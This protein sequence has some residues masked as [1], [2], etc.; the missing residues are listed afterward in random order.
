[1][2]RIVAALA[3]LAVLAVAGPAAAQGPI[4]ECGSFVP[5][6]QSGPP[7]HIAYRGYWTFGLVGPVGHGFTPVANLTTRNV[8]CRDARSASLTIVQINRIYPWHGFVLRFRMTGSERGTEDYDI[9]CTRG[10]EV[11]HWQSGGSV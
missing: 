3:V 9:R 11:I 2:K 6:G 4:R 5:T 7:A 8:S 1:M 10:G